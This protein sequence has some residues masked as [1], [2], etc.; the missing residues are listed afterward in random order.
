MRGKVWIAAG[1]VLAMAGCGGGGGGV[2]RAAGGGSG[3]IGRACMAADRAAAT[4][5]MCGCIQQVANQTLSGRDQTRAAKFFRDPHAAQEARQSDS[6]SSEAF[7]GRYKVFAATA[8]QVCA[9][10]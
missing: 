2:T 10:G 8:E 9:A 4:P 1:L 6:R 3:P 5:Q 7:W